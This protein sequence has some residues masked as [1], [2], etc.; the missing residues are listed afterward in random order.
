MMSLGETKQCGSLSKSFQNLISTAHSGARQSAASTS[1]GN[2][3]YAD[4]ALRI[5]SAQA[6]PQKETKPEGGHLRRV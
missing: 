4:H 2:T 1:P 3:E 5:F 6:T